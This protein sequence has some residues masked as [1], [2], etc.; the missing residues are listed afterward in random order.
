LR[1]EK[2]LT[3]GENIQKSF[4]L[5]GYDIHATNKRLFKSSFDGKTVA[6][7]DYDHIS[8]IV[9][10]VKRYYWLIPVGIAISALTW[11]YVNGVH[12]RLDSSPL[13]WLGIAAGILCVVIGILYKKEYM[14]IFV[15]GVP[16]PVPLDGTRADL[17][18]LLRIVREK[19]G[20]NKTDPHSESPEDD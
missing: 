17:D 18:D 10:H 16:Q 1:I 5:K 11:I 20:Q 14:K 9:F 2:Y 13:F 3:Q 7:Y 6:D 4:T 12:M 8:S 15:V 19:V